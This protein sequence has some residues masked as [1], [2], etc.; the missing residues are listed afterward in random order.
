[1]DEENNCNYINSVGFRKLCNMKYINDDT[2]KDGYDFSNLKENTILY[3]KSDYLSEFSNLIN[4]IPN[5]FILVSGCSDYTIP[6]D[7]FT[8]DDFIK[9]INN[10]KIIHWF[11]QNNVYKHSKITNLPVGL[12]YHTIYNNLNHEWG[13]FCSPLEQEIILKYIKDNSI[14]FSERIKKCYANFQFSMIAKYGYDRENAYKNINKDLVFYENNK[15]K[16][17]DTWKNQSKYAFVI[18][19]HGNGLDCHRT[20]EA[21][22]LGCIPIV[23]KSNIDILY[24]DLPVLIIDDWIDITDELLTDTINSFKDKHF[25][26]NILTLKYWIEKFNSYKIE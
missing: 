7:I 13:N 17:V 16:R 4:N 24:K 25:N 9:F 3:I 1:M 18:S 2:Y 12:D 5:K 10:D 15:I 14:N 21:L 23:K 22:I 26:Y 19:P 20:W 8:N 6:N 11:S